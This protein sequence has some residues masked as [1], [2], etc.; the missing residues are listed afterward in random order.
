VEV[1]ENYQHDVQERE[2]KLHKYDK[3]PA[4]IRVI[5]TKTILMDNSSI[6]EKPQ[7]VEEAPLRMTQTDHDASNSG[8]Q[9]Y[10]LQS[11][12]TILSSHGYSNSR[13]SPKNQ[14]RI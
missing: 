5:K 7:R 10:K 3:S 14:T 12:N 13:T 8:I 1:D 2:I 11:S 9:S 4:K 6:P